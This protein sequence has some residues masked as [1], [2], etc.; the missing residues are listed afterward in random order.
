M[1]VSNPL[2]AIPCAAYASRRKFSVSPRTYVL[3]R[4]NGEGDR[5]Q[6]GDRRLCL[7]LSGPF[8]HASHGPSPAPLSLRRGGALYFLQLDLQ[9]PQRTLVM[10]GAEFCGD[11]ILAAGPS[12]EKRVMFADRPI[13]T[14]LRL[15]ML[16][17]IALGKDLK[18]FENLHGDA[19][20]AGPHQRKVKGAIE[21]GDGRV[22]FS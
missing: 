11:R 16:D 3:P 12:F 5:A 18:P 2:A 22:L 13:V 9:I 6:R 20:A 14:S 1:R 7:K 21:G 19:T 15:E 4:D 17:D 8:H 10:R